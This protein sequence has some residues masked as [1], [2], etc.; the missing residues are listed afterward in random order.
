MHLTFDSAAPA[1]E[2][3]DVEQFLAVDVRIGTILGAEEFP[4]ARKPAYKLQIDFG[5]GVGT[6]RSSA[7]ITDRYRVDELIGR[8]VLG[9]VNLP[10]RQIGPFVSEVLVLGFCEADGAVLLASVDLPVVNGTR[11]S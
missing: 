10:P 8:Q 4:E 5:P 3:I 1:A 7:Q 11:M 9:V 6:R 2:T